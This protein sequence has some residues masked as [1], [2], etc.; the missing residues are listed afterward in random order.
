MEKGI[1]SYKQIYKSIGF[2]GGS[3]VVV[4]LIGIIRTK[5]L[6][7]LLG[8]SGVGIV[9]VFQN[10]IDLVRNATGFGINYSGVKKIADISLNNT[11]YNI[12]K[13]IKILKTWS[14]GTGLLGMLLM[15]VFSS[16]FSQISFSSNKYTFDLICLSVVVFFSS[17]S[18]GQI[19]LLQGLGKIKEMAMAS[20]L[21]AL[22]GTVISI[23]VYW[24]LGLRG[25]IAGMLLTSITSLFSSWYYSNFI[26]INKIKLSLKNIFL[27]GLDMAKT[28]IFIVATIF[29]SSIFMY[30][31]R[32]VILKKSDFSSVGLFQ[33]VWTISNIYINVLLN[34][35]LADYFPRLSKFSNDNDASNKLINE[36]LEITLLAG[37]PMLIVLLSFSSIVLELLY[38][39][40][41]IGALPIL[42]WQI[43]SSFITL[44]VWPLSVIFIAR[45]KGLFMFASEI[46]K[47]SIYLFLIFFGWDFLGIDVLGIGFFIS[48]ISVLI[49]TIGS[50]GHITEFKFSKINK[51]NICVLFILITLAYVNLHFFNGFTQLALNSI[52]SFITTIYCMRQLNKLVNF[53]SILNKLQI[54]K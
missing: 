10:I 33:S 6:A 22:L 52:L 54:F 15:V 51:M 42:E 8:P 34:A 4:I 32:M 40:S 25:I 7:I 23:P 26:Q 47:Q 13:T 12:S 27:G 14:L 43:Y 36:Q 11:P 20:I 19:V 37:A 30:L 46:F 16:Y 21:G 53:K 3:Q 48:F 39:T 29:V 2:I 31:I 5:V 24:Y 35:M 50:V 45:N 41:F 17:I 1:S 18:A 38:S 49:F 28:G 9:G 44:V